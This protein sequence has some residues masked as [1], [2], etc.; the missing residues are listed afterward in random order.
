MELQVSALLSFLYFFIHGSESENLSIMSNSLWLHGLYNPRNSPGQ[1]TGV[2]S[3]SLLQGIFPEQGSNPGLPHCRQ[4]LYQLSHRGSPYTWKGILFYLFFI[5]ILFI[6]LILFFNFTIL[7]WFCHISTWIHN[8]YTR[9]PHPKPSS[10]P[11]HPSGSSQCTSPKHPVS[12]IEPGLATHFIYDITHVSMPFSQIIPP[13]PSP[14][15]SKRLFYTSVSLLLS[16]IQGYCYHL[17][18]IQ[19]HVHVNSKLTIYPS[20]QSFHPVSI[21]LSS[22]SVSLFLLF[23]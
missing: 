12:C 19:Q 20:S 1:N 3:L 23:K 13:S 18:K 9:V 6:Y 8:R 15:E 17:S 10:L 14:T 22:K 11:Y 4:I 7:S 5:F 21:S 2:H 16:R